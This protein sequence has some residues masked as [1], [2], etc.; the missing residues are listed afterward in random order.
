[1]WDEYGPGPIDSY[2]CYAM[3]LRPARCNGCKFAQLEHE[4]GDK[5][6]HLQDKGW[7]NIYELDAG[8]VSGQGEPLEHEG[9]PICFR[10]GFLSIQ[11]SDEC[12]H[13]KPPSV[14]QQK[15]AL[16]PQ[17]ASVSRQIGGNIV[18]VLK[19]VWWRRQSRRWWRGIRRRYYGDF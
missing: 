16:R 13:W 14:P 7:H 4:L 10:A 5:F 8:P 18:R 15:R 9:Q 17:Q 2:D 6:L 3:G 19:R 12:Y 1:M 11:H